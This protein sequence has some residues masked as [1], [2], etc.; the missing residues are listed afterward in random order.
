MNI[1]LLLPKVKAHIQEKHAACSFTAVDS[2]FIVTSQ[3]WW[4][5]KIF[6]DFRNSVL[7]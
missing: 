5:P 7:S 4:K 3:V 1:T 6:L 2:D